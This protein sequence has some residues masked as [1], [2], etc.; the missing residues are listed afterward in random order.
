MY[1][2]AFALGTKALPTMRVQGWVCV[3]VWVPV[4]TYGWERTPPHTA[5]EVEQPQLQIMRPLKIM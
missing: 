5:I 4:S 2:P 3:W 1:V